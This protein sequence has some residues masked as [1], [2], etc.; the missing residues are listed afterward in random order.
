[1]SFL[2]KLGFVR[3]EPSSAEL[4]LV[5]TLEACLATVASERRR[6]VAAFAALLARVAYADEEISEG[7]ADRIRAIVAEHG[8][9]APEETDAVVGL[10]RNG[11]V[12]LRGQQKNLLTRAFNEVAS[13]AD[14][15]HLVD[16]LYAVATAD[17]LVTHVEDREIR[18][19][20]DA[21]LLPSGDVLAIRARYR[22]KL[23]E[24]Q[25]LRALRGR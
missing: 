2:R 14:R 20:A 16:C 7:E 4:G 18:L 23:E 5:E 11:T 6:Y 13:E 15:R 1:M 10:A 19:V 3:G 21:L 22:D 9:L 8:G 24:L 25:R 17:D 12:A